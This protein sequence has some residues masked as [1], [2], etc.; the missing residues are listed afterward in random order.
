MQLVGLEQGD[1]AVVERKPRTKFF[2][3]RYG[4]ALRGKAIT[5]DHTAPHL[6]QEMPIAIGPQPRQRGWSGLPTDTKTKR[7]TNSCERRTRH[8]QNAAAA[9]M[10]MYGVALGVT[11][12]PAT[13]SLAS[14]CSWLGGP[15]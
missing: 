2:V 8:S 14:R 9:R 3:P 12:A 7:W 13:S 4:N 1:D 6:I 5:V 10:Y 11:G 15:R